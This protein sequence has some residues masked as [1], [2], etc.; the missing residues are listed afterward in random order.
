M[1]PPPRQIIFVTGTDT[2]AGK[3]LL[4]ALLL[5]QL[6]ANGCH[7]LA[8]KP[9]CSGGQADVR[10]LQSL[11][12]GELTDEEVNPFYFPEPIAPLVSL[13]KSGRKI[14]LREVIQRIRNVA[15]RC[16]TLI[17]EGSGGLLVP[18]AENV[19]VLNLV[20]KLK[21][22]VIVAGR[23]RLGII[24]HTLLT[25]NA[26]KDNSLRD[27]SVVLMDT[28]DLDASAATNQKVLTEILDLPVW[29]ISFLGNKI[30]HILKIKDRHKKIK[31]ILA[32][33]LG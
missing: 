30:G 5:Y 27:V 4:T 14:G 25:V 7:A 29:R 1:K 31:K 26:L 12:R 18:L 20:A 19:T 23:N 2:G 10:L 6:R 3:T 15:R 9:F 33:I 21:P 28:V 17:V 13:Q 24:N 11:Q 16:D 32:Q 22:K 8:M